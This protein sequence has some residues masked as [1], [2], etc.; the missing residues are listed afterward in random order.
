MVSAGS[1]YSSQVVCLLLVVVGKARPAQSAQLDR[2]K[3][4]VVA[5][6]EPGA[7]VLECRVSCVVCAMNR[8]TWKAAQA[9]L[10]CDTA[11][12]GWM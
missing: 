5:R 1:V 8:P 9:L 10:G 2:L 4:C 3:T 7:L 11:G 12:Q 6:Y